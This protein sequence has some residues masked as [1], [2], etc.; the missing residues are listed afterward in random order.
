MKQKKIVALIKNSAY[1]ELKEEI[2]ELF[3]NED[4][5][6]ETMEDERFDFLL[7]FQQLINE[8]KG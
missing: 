1:E 8:E 5:Q 7:E 3:E 2:P 4:I 6:I